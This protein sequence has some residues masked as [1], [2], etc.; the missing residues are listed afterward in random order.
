MDGNVFINV[1][2]NFIEIFSWRPPI[3]RDIIIDFFVFNLPWSVVRVKRPDW[4]ALEGY[5]AEFEAVGLA[6]GY[7]VKVI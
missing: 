7:S 6:D 5:V 1:N 3:R 2:F 4:A